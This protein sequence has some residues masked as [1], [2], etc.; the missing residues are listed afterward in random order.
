[1]DLTI[2][3]EP[4]YVLACT[5]GAIDESAESQ[6]RNLLFPLVGQAG[7]Q[8]ILD[9]SQSPRISSRGVGL[10]VGLVAHANTHSS[11]VVLAA[12]TELRVDCPDPQP[13]GPVLRN[14]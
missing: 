13:T 4:G 6:F 7:T 3:H 2:S 1:M 5:A 10:L 9:L 8:L 12:C 11:R 14:R